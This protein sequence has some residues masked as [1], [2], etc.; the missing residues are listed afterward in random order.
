MENKAS[1][2]S[3]STASSS[4]CKF[5]RDVDIRRAQREHTENCNEARSQLTQTE[6]TVSDVMNQVRANI[7]HREKF[8]PELR[9]LDSRLRCLHLVL[10]GPVLSLQAMI[11][12]YQG[13]TTD[14]AVHVSSGSSDSRSLG[15]LGQ[16]PP[17]PGYERLLTI[18][19]VIAEGEALRECESSSELRKKSAELV[20]LVALILE[21]KSAT[22]NCK[23]D[24]C[25]AQT[26]Y[27]KAVKAA[28][29][30]ANREKA[31]SEQKK[32]DADRSGDGSASTQRSAIFVC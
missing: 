12:G 10:C 26:A 17:I 5:D 25:N 29:Q 13:D 27:T 6:K 30:K 20:H 15:Q 7:E 2:P 23:D 19:E 9:N 22:L 11:K 28:Q 16:T 1:E 24:L 14:S 21:L 4:S 31:K 8:A 3:A 18:D 32:A